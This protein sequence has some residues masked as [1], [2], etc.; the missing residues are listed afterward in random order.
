MT[1]TRYIPE[2]ARLVTRP[3]APGVQVYLYE[4]NGAPFYM[5]FRSEKV[6]KHQEHHSCKD[7]AAR[8]SYVDRFFNYWGRPAKEKAARK[9]RERNG[10]NPFKVGDILLNTWGYE[11]TNH[12]FYEVVATTPKTITIRQVKTRELIDPVVGMKEP[13]DMRSRVEAVRGV[14]ED[15]KAMVKKVAFD[16]D[17]K[18]YVSMEFGS[19]ELWGG[20]VKTSTHYA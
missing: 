6:A 8:D 3:E 4:K 2:G 19:C 13:Y 11:Q 12:D 20:E 16:S 15:D 18:G 7:E 10:V 5:G 17:G 14:Y 1:K 9:E